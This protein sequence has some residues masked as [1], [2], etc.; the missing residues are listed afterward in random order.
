MSLTW[1]LILGFLFA[2]VLQVSQMLISGYFTSKLQDAT[3]QVSSSLQANLAVQ[4]SIDAVRL[5]Q[6]RITEDLGPANANI[7]LAVYKVYVEEACRQA[8]SFAE[9]LANTPNPA[10]APVAKQVASLAQGMKDLEAQPQAAL[11]DEVQFFEDTVRDLEQAL[12]GAQLEIK[13]LAIAGVE[14]EREVSG[15]PVRA[16]LVI[17]L[18]GVVLMA[19]FVAWFSRQLVIPIERA[20]AELEQRVASRTAELATSVENLEEQITER[21]RVEG[22]KEELNRQLVDASRRAGMAELATGVLHNVGNVLNSVNTSSTLLLDGLRKSKVDGLKRALVLIGDH[23]E[24]LAS[25]ITESEQGQMLPKYLG[26]LSNHLSNERDALVAEANDLST[27]V[28]HMMEIVSR[29]QSYACVSNS[30]TTMHLSSIIDDVLSM[31]MASFADCDV[32]VEKS[33]NFD[34]ALP[35][36]RSR[37]MQIFMNLVGNARRAIKDTNRGSGT[38]R[39]SLDQ[40]G[41]DRIRVSIVDDGVGISHEGLTKIFNHGFTT[42]SDGHGFGLHHSANAASEMGGKL[43]AESDGVG[44]GATFLLELPLQPDHAATSPDA[45]QPEL[46]QPS[47]QGAES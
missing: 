7:D 37:V 19:A 27:R 8:E 14:L 1:K 17:T 26:Q 21:K 43:W 25:F 6:N 18:G 24:D 4:N 28:T 45:A 39:I 20:W 2:L 30:L 12:L 35:L 38:L 32:T 31:H 42:K 29:Q 5:L 40:Q 13:A 22:Q 3:Q 9:A 47:L 15:L 10:A 34:E 46:A 11:S 36:D 44:L 41:D 16:G 23:E 33:F